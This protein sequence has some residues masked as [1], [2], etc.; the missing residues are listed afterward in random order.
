[1]PRYIAKP[2]ALKRLL[3]KITHL[4]KT[5]V[6]GKTVGT[7]W[8]LPDQVVPDDNRIV[9]LRTESKACFRGRF[10]SRL[11]KD[12]GYWCNQEFDSVTPIAWREL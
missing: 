5:R 10:I 8:F 12:G 11:A 4:F 6:L 1:M 3:T 2:S 9:V 7:L